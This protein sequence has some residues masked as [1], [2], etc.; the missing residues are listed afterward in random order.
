MKTEKQDVTGSP[1]I[2]VF[3]CV[4]VTENLVITKLNY[5]NEILV[6]PTYLYLTILRLLWDKL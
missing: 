2:C 4:Y 6:R 1:I 3:T 5:K